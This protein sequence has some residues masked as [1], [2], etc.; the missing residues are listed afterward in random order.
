MS[1]FG[2]EKLSVTMII[3]EITINQQKNYSLSDSGKLAE[4]IN[5]DLTS[6]QMLEMCALTHNYNCQYIEQVMKQITTQADIDRFAGIVKIFWEIDVRNNRHE[7]VY[8]NTMTRQYEPYTPDFPERIDQIVENIRRIR[9][10]ERMAKR[11]WN[12]WTVEHESNASRT[13]APQFHSAQMVLP[14]EDGVVTIRDLD[15]NA[16]GI[17]NITNDDDFAEFVDIC[18]NEIW[19]WLQFKDS[20]RLQ[21]RPKK[22]ANVVRFVLRYDGIVDKDC[23]VRNFC[24]LFN[25]IVPEACLKDDT[26]SSRDDANM[27]SKKFYTYEN[28][29]DY[30]IL[31][32]DAKELRKMLKPVADKLV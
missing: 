14:P 9:E 15:A 13:K 6:L 21:A 25:K 19:P 7:V 22:D 24:L 11:H 1:N 18:R 28:L 23:S 16:Q 10:L 8:L 32:K 29:P 3:S 5:N 2:G 31:K 26:V 12:E 17:L 20:K 27:Q 30:N 4:T